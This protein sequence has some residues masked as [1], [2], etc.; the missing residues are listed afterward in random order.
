MTETAE[1]EDA[2]PVED[3]PPVEEA[4]PMAEPVPAAAPAYYPAVAPPPVTYSDPLPFWPNG[5]DYQQTGRIEY[6]ETEVNP[7]TGTVVVRSPKQSRDSS[8][9][10]H[11]VPCSS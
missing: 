5:T 1:G 3:A 8:G 2:A 11:H 9:N 10:I 6:V 4:P 7:Q